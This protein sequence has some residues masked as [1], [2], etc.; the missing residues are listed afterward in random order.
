MAHPPRTGLGLDYAPA[1]P[2]SRAHGIALVGAGGIVSAG[3][4]P[5]YRAAG[6]PVLGV[7]DANLDRARATATAFDIPRVYANVAELVADPA[8]EIVDVAVYPWDQPA[9]VAQAVAAGKHLLCQKPLADTFDAAVTS[10]ETARAA[11]VHLAVNQQMRWDAGIRYANR[12]IERGYLGIPTYAEIRVHVQTD[13]SLWPWFS[14]GEKIE[15][16]YHSIHYIDSLRHL[17]GEPDH[18]FTSG[19]RSPGETTRAETRTLTVWEYTAGLQVSIDVSHGTW[20]DDAFAEFRFEGT[21]GVIKGTIGLMY[22]YPNGR[23][24]TMEAMSRTFDDGAW[25]A[26]ELQTRWFPDAFVGPMASLMRAIED[27]GEPETSGADNLKTLAIVF[28]QYRSIA[29]RRAVA[30]NE[31]RTTTNTFR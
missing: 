29:E 4:L 5:A 16:L 13:W 30:P 25:I 1:M 24:D 20:Q 19:S 31:I 23:P 12:L 11:G 14:S 2:R 27:D 6:F 21:E 17:F 7:T 26:P 9:I 10:V 18:V 3:H 15:I 28:A 22:D 8:V